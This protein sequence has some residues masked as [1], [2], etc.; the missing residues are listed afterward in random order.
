MEAIEDQMARF[1]HLLAERAPACMSAAR[2]SA[3]KRIP[4]AIYMT[5]DE[6]ERLI[7]DRIA[8][9]DAL[10]DGAE[11]QTILKEIAQLRVYAD[12]KRWIASSSPAR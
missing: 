6:I 2:S 10:P 7:E 12:A 4:K 3:M 9:A 1:C 8:D 5:A 11:R